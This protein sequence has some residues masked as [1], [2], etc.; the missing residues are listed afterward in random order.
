VLPDIPTVAEAG[1]PGFEATIWLGLM[2]P[3]RTPKPI[4]EKLN[5]AINRTIARPELVAAWDRQGATPMVMTTAEL[6][7]FLRKDIEKWAEVARLAGAA[8]R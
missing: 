3:A 5:A 2:A 4:V 8:A 7:A 1:V 6:D